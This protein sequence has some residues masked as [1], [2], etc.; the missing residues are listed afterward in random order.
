MTT[1]I[2][3]FSTGHFEHKELTHER[4]PDEL[5]ADERNDRQQNPQHGLR[6]QRDPEEA[7]VRRVDVADRG[8]RTLK[9]PAAV[10][11]GGV[12]LVPPAQADEAAARNVLEVVEVRGEQ[13][14]GD[15]ED[16][17]EVGGE[18]AQTEEVDEE[19]C[20]MGLLAAV[21]VVG[22]SGRDVQTRKK[23]KVSSVM[24]WLLRRQLSVPGAGVCWA[25][26]MA[27]RRRCVRDSFAWAIVCAGRKCF[28]H[29]S[30]RRAFTWHVH[31]PRKQGRGPCWASAGR[32]LALPRGVSS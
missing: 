20:W 27:L 30:H 3:T 29:T 2:S 7:L 21:V 9:D 28:K 8:I 16:E 18:E 19:A 1:T 13:E 14:D 15:D 5:E 12:N 24:G 22:C 10:A 31:G 32:R 4:Q 6:V 25:A 17:D 11:R 23:R 26:S